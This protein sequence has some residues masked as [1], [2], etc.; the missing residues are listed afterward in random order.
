MTLRILY[1]GIRN[2]LP[3]VDPASITTLKA[4]MVVAQ[5]SSG[6]IVPCDGAT[7]EP[8]GLL[9]NDAAGNAYES[10]S[11]VGS[12]KAPYVCGNGVY[13]VDADGYN[14][15]EVGGA[16]VVG[17]KLFAGTG[18]TEGLL[19]CTDPVGGAGVGTYVGVITKAPTTDDPFMQLQMYL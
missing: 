9:I 6:N 19:T 11:A 10:S 13:E 1:V 17:A 7:M 15:A 3:D 16:F 5:N 18:A 8:L 2:S 12:G 4:G 14:A